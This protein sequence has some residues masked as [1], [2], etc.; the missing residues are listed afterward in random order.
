MNPS[1][2]FYVTVNFEQLKI[3]SKNAKQ[4]RENGH[5][6]LWTVSKNALVVSNS[7]S[8]RYPE[9]RHLIDTIFKRLEMKLRNDWPVSKL[10]IILTTTHLANEIRV[11]ETVLEN[12]HTRSDFQSFLLLIKSKTVRPIFSKNYIN[13]ASTY[14]SVT[15][16]AGC[17]GCWSLARHGLFTPCVRCN[18]QKFHSTLVRK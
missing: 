5:D 1:L 11:L 13:V 3:I 14:I 8:Q 7:H 16:D 9:R 6:G 17:L 12:P 4:Y 2:H 15:A 18:L 10:R